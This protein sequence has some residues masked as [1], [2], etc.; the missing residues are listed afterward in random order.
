MLGGGRGT[1]NRHFRGPPFSP[2]AWS[3]FHVK[4][5]RFE[6]P[7]DLLLALVERRELDVT[8][9]AVVDVVDQYLA[10][11]RSDTRIDPDLLADFVALGARLIYLKSLALVPRP[12]PLVVQDAESQDAA[13]D[14]AAVL[15]EYRRFKA[16]A[17]A[18]RAREQAGLRSFPR[19]VPIPPQPPAP[20]LNGVTLERLLVI[21]QEALRRRPP[22]PPATVPQETVT[23]R[24]RLGA[25]ERLLSRDGRLSFTAFIA[26][27]RTR[28]E[29]VVGFMAVLELI[30]SGRA[31]AVQAEPFGDIELIAHPP[32][33]LA[34][35]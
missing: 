7:L 28:I 26:A 30:K 22:D 31:A 34:G 3:V 16:A 33:A 13:E 21:V 18:F 20:G 17:E 19:L 24:D 10:Y 25:L 27:S 12:A 23:V 35:D 6:G 32:V 2:Y 14:L 29:V 5:S 8:A 11:L 15:H 4:L 1:V 9:I